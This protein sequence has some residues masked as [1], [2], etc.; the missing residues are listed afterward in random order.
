MPVQE[1]NQGPPQTVDV[2]PAT[3]QTIGEENVDT[4]V[5][6]TQLFGLPEADGAAV[7][8]TEDAKPAPEAANDDAWAAS[9]LKLAGGAETPPELAM[10]AGTLQ[11]GRLATCWAE[12]T[13]WT[14]LAM[15]ARKAG[16]VGETTHVEDRAVEAMLDSDGADTDSRGISSDSC[17]R[18]KAL[19]AADWLLR[20]FLVFIV[21]L[22]SG[23]ETVRESTKI[24]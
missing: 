17:T 14:A 13:C 9:W 21:F 7:A 19:H 23:T 20:V 8:G 15:V 1:K 2:K 3:K 12:S 24:R 16:D 4:K 11:P 18:D 10:L 6:T 22:V 5:G